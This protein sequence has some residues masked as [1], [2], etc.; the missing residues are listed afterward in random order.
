MKVSLYTDILEK[1][2]GFPQYSFVTLS[3]YLRESDFVSVHVPLDK[4]K[5]AVI[6]KV[7]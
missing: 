3:E 7:K 2:E 6:S 4:E 5:G 1:A